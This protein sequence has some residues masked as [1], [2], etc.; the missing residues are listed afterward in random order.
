MT[1]EQALAAIRDE[2]GD[3]TPPTD[4]DLADALAELG[5]WRLVTLRVLRRRRAAMVG[6]GG[7]IQTVALSGVLS[8][9]YGSGDLRSLDAQIIRLQ[10]LYD[11]DQ[12]PPIVDESQS[13]RIVR[14]GAR[15]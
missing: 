5:D 1:E 6:A 10:G 8:V 15:G 12:H 4:D 2:I 7:Q 3:N 11:A 9:G 14:A 13:R